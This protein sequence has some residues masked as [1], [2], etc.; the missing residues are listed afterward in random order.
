MIKNIILRSED[1]N[2]EHRTPL[3]PSDVPILLLNGFRIFVER[4]LQRCF[5]DEEYSKC[6]AILID[7]GSWVKFK[8]I[9]SVIL[10]LK[11]IDN[12]DKLDH[13][14][15]IYFSHL[16][17]T[18]SKLLDFFKKTNSCIMDLEHICDKNNKR[19]VAFGY[20]A[21]YIGA[22]VG[23]LH[24]TNELQMPTK[25]WNN[26][27]IWNNRKYLNVAVIGHNGRCGI[28]VLKLLEKYSSHLN[29]QCYDRVRDK[30]DLCT[31]DII[32]NCIFLDEHIKPFVTKNDIE[33][34]NH[35]LTIVD[36]SCDPCHPHNPLPI[37]SESG[38]WDKYNIRI[39]EHVD[40]ISIDNLPS[41]L[42]IDSS[43]YFS[44]SL[45][46]L[47]LQLNNDND[48]IWKRAHDIFINTK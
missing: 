6:G 38:S 42:P 5:D 31:Y 39:N 4:S 30:S 48:C 3:I 45:V 21:G 19:L 20:Y 43:I 29:I 44:N 35:K 37:Y 41:L 47:L 16:F 22:I 33:K 1:K 8:K 15:H 13:H 17:K 18:N 28:G 25:Y 24:H 11:Y 10:G 14:T 9:D 23:L 34:I 2:N 27:P 7:K 36:I 46:N 40:V 32:Y 12:I 26:E